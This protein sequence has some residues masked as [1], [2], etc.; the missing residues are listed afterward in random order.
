MKTGTEFAENMVL[1]QSYE[2]IEKHRKKQI[3]IKLVNSKNV[4]LSNLPVRVA[5]KRHKFLFGCIYFGFDNLSEREI[6]LYNK[7]F[8]ELFNFAV[9]PFY[10]RMF[11]PVDGKPNYKKINMLINWCKKYDITFKGHPLV[12]FSNWRTRPGMP[13]WLPVKNET[14]FW[15]RTKRRVEECV[16]YYK[17][18]IDIW[19]I[20]NEPIAGPPKCFKNISLEDYVIQPI[21][22]AR[23]KNPDAKL[24]VNDFHV[25]SGLYTTKF[26]NFL[27]NIEKR[28]QFDGIGIQAHEPRTERFLLDRVVKILDKY[29]RLGKEIHITEFAPVSRGRITGSWKKGN[30]TEEKQSDWVEKFY[31]VVFAHPSVASINT[32]GFAEKDHWLKGGGLLRKDFKPKLAYDKLKQLITEEWN[33]KVTGRTDKEGKFSFSGFLGKYEVDILI[34]KGIWEKYHYEFDTEKSTHCCVNIK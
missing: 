5:L 24:I 20:V 13:G 6:R 8:F 27:S 31:R 10:W 23:A 32:W 21:K 11:E 14:L 30:W 29:S 15:P 17:N 2:N 4:P 25:F 3:E 26:F 16:S 28:V 19:D 34:S 1:E 9:L 18:K 33:T 12:W 7:Y 22:W